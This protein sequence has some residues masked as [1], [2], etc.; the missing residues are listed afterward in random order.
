ME[1]PLHIAFVGFGILRVASRQKG[2]FGGGQLQGQGLDNALGNSILQ[3]EHIS[4]VTVKPVS[5]E[6]GSIVGIYELQGDPNLGT[7][8]LKLA[9]E[10]RINLQLS[11]DFDESLASFCKLQN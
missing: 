1:P 4:Q 10:D 7:G 3:R 5:P 8:T 9:F 2:S 11:A 6:R